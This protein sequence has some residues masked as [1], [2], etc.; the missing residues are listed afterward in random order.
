MRSSLSQD[1][2]FLFKK[3]FL[4]VAFALLGVLLLSAFTG[5]CKIICLVGSPAIPTHPAKC[6]L[7]SAPLLC[8][9][10]ATKQK[11]MPVILQPK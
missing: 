8:P 7:C 2:E 5:L 11:P 1:L 4:L 10:C 6:S 3:F 9:S